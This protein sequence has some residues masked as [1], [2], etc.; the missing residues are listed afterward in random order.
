[1]GGEQGPLLVATGAQTSLAAGEGNEHLVPATRA[2]DTGKSEVEIAA[3]EV[4]AGHLADDGP[5]ASV[6]LLVTLVVGAFKFR[7][8]P[9]DD[10]VERRLPRL[11]RPV[12][13]CHLRRQ[14]DHEP[15]AFRFE[16][17]RVRNANWNAI[18]YD[19][20]VH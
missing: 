2:A 15:A 18:E 9:F 7:I 14:A 5:P 16:A 4:L 17:G 3:A 12:D 8:V 10:L 19:T 6:T 20:C 13:G 1:M 11:A